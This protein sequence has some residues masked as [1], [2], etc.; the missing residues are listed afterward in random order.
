MRLIND[1]ALPAVLI[2][3]EVNITVETRLWII[4]LHVWKSIVYYGDILIY[5]GV[6]SGF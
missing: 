6:Y 4:R 2:R 3:N 5:W 1:F